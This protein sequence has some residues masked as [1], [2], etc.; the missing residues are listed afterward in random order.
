[1][2][3]TKALTVVSTTGV[4]PSSGE[5]YGWVMMHESWSSPLLASFKRSKISTCAMAER[6]TMTRTPSNIR[7]S[8]R[9]RVP[10][11]H[12]YTKLGLTLS[13]NHLVFCSSSSFW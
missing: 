7:A 9:T 4:T 13:T 6:H 2:T 5:V 1:M 12:E 11:T 3:R 8:E 10:A